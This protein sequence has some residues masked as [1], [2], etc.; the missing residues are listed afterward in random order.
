MVSY[1]DKHNEAKPFMREA[2]EGGRRV[3]GDEDRR[4]LFSISVMGTL[5]QNQGMLDDAEPYYREVLE[6]NR[7]VH[8]DEHY[9]T[10]VA[11]C[12]MGSLMLGQVRLDEAETYFQE[13]LETSRRV[14]GDKSF[15]WR[16]QA[17]RG[18]AHKPATVD[19]ALFTKACTDVSWLVRRAALSGS[20]RTKGRAANAD[21]IAALSDQDRRV[22][23][24]DDL[25]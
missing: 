1:Q 24:A 2:I 25:P 20:A 11:I 23:V 17:M 8:G 3:F 21:L 22:Q 7:H 16:P 5:L 6:G 15:L 14:F 12:N 4:T 10:L 18:L 13:A 9:N 19:R